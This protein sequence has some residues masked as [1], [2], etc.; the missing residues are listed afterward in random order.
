ML[1]R[2]NCKSNQNWRCCHAEKAQE[3]SAAEISQLGPGLHAVGGVAG[4]LLRVKPTGARQWVLRKKTGT[5]CRD[6]GLGG[7]PDVGLSDA[8]QK[9]R[10]F[11]EQIEAGVDPVAERQAAKAALVAAQTLGI[12]FTEAA[13]QCHA[14]KSKGFQNAKHAAQWLTTLETYAFPMIGKLPVD[15]V[16]LAHIVKILEPIWE[17][18]T[19]TAS[20]IRQR[21]E[22][23]LAWAAVRDF[24]SGDNSARWRGQLDAVLAKPSAVSQVPHHRALP[25]DDVPS[26]MVELRQRNGLAAPA[27]EFLILTATRNGEVRGATWEEINLEAL[28]WTIPAERMKAKK[29]YRVPLSPRAIEILETIPRIEGDPYIFPAQRGGKL[30][31]MALT[32]VLRRMNVNAVPHGFRSTFRDWCGERTSY[33]HEVAEMTLAHTI[34]SAVERAYRRGDLLAKRAKLMREWARFCAT[35][36]T[37]SEVA[38]IRKVEC[39]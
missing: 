2:L 32:T 14:S 37:S 11:R 18:K 1:D 33:P 24:R 8:R 38:P 28:T 15:Q 17:T 23:V 4:L 7:F 13:R 25:L 36:P 35:A 9:A 39:T 16:E 3:K 10:G 26:F 27:L 20:R 29:E 5:K 12:T 31:D 30:S 21:I 34:S 6:I 22:Q 19:E